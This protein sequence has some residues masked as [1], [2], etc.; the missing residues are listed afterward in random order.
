MDRD[1]KNINAR[2]FAM[3]SSRGISSEAERRAF[4][5]RLLSEGKVGAPSCRNWARRDYSNAID[6]LE[7]IPVGAE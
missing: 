1:L 5:R 6:E 7:Q 2:Y 4:Q 3:L